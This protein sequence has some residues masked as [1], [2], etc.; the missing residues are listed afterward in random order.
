M[1]TTM[2]RSTINH[3]HDILKLAGQFDEVRA[4]VS[5]HLPA[6]RASRV[7]DL[8]PRRAASPWSAVG[9]FCAGAAVGAA[10][11][12]TLSPMKGAEL[13]GEI[14]RRFRNVG[15]PAD[16][17]AHDEMAP[18]SEGSQNGN[19]TRGSRTTDHD[20]AVARSV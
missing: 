4:L 5:Q 10:T 15:K 20:Q 9:W 13:R 1:N 2:L 14:A 19:G 3:A 18:V 16:D 6:F 11:A 7:L 17:S 8:L 12:L